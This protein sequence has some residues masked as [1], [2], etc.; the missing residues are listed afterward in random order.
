VWKFDGYVTSDSGAIHD[1]YADHKWVATGEEATAAALEAG[2]DI[3]SGS[4]YTQ[5]IAKAIA[6]GVLN[7]TLVNDALT[8][9]FKVRMRLGL[10]DPADKV[11]A[12]YSPTPDMVGT[13]ANHQLSYEAS[14]QGLV[15]LQNKDV[16]GKPRGP[17]SAGTAAA[18]GGGSDSIDSIDSIKALPLRKGIRIAVIGPNANG[19]TVRSLMAGGTGGGTLS[20]QV[21][22]KVSV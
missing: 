8:R 7:E 21:V 17:S 13:A 10:F 18:G 5:F 20:A 9:A 4:V 2:C 19:T 22:C 15:L 11:P 16:S 3:N 1:I 12:S 14:T 6:S